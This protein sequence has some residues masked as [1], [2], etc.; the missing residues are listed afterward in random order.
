MKSRY[1]IVEVVWRDSMGYGGWRSP[2]DQARDME[3]PQAMTNRTCGYL[4]GSTDEHVA[5]TQS[6]SEEWKS[7]KE[8]IQIP[9]ACVESITYLRSK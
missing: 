3:K 5:I 1:P 2:D 7:V 6:Y 9:K 8:T 4:L